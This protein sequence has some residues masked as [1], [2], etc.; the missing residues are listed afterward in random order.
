VGEGGGVV[1]LGGGGPSLV[2]RAHMSGGARFELKLF[3]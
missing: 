1:L 2:G 3:V